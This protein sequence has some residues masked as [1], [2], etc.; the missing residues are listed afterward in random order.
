M[1]LSLLSRY[2][3]FAACM[4]FTL[5]S[6]PF[7]GAAAWLWP[8]TL[9][10]GLLTL[11]GLYNLT[12]TRHAVLRNYPVIGNIRYLVEGIRP[13]IRQYLLES[14][15]ERVPFSRDQRALVYRRAKNVGGDKP[16]GTLVEVYESGYEFIG[17]STRP[18]PV[19]DPKTFRVRIGGPQCTQPY[20]AS[21]MNISAMSFGSLSANAIRAL[22][23]GRSSAISITTRARAASAPI[24]AR[25]AATWSGSWAAAISAAGR[26]MAVSI[27][28]SSPRSR[29]S[30]RSR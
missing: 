26:R 7:V 6:L 30:R 24:T 14:D 29:P 3:V 16:F 12:Q 9:A 25:W 2:A 27:R 11:L 23:K 10:A 18:V 22:N 28:A 21:I 8:L 20:S 19:P 1:H 17:H 4:L 15:R 13:E 5:G